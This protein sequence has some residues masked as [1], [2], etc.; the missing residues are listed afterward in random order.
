MKQ[1]IGGIVGDPQ[2]DVVR[3]ESKVS[4][5]RGTNAVVGIFTNEQEL[6]ILHLRRLKNLLEDQSP[7]R[8]SERLPAIQRIIVLSSHK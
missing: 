6:Y 2:S 7:F 4:D 1:K 8:S 5:I 3:N